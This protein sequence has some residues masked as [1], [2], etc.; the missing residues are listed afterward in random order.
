MELQLVVRAYKRLSLD[1]FLLQVFVYKHR[2]VHHDF[3]AQNAG[4]NVVLH[5]FCYKG[6]RV[7]GEVQYALFDFG[8]SIMLPEESKIEELIETRPLNYAHRNA[9]YVEGPLSYNPFKADIAFLGLELQGRVP[10]N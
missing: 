2:I 8:N 3:L 5:K 10:T 4:I 1:W 7:P 6:L 9:K